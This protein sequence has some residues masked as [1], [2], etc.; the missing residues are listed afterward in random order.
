MAT[1]AWPLI[2]HARSLYDA[3]QCDRAVQVL[4]EAVRA[5]PGHREARGLLAE[6]LVD[7]ER[8]PDA[9]GVLEEAAGTSMPLEWLALKGLC[10]EA[11][12]DGTSASRI[13]E[14]LTQQD[15]GCVHGL[16]I[17]GR[18]AAR[19][20]DAALSERCFQEALRRDSR[21]GLA[22]LGLARLQQAAGDDPVCLEWLGKAFRSCPTSRE[23]VLAFHEQLIALNRLA[24]GEE[25]FRA[26]LPDHPLNRRLR[27]LLID[28]LLRQGKL[29]PA[30]AAVES[31]MAD[32]GVDAGILAAAG[33]VR[34]RLGPLRRVERG[35][36]GSDSV[37]LCM[38]VKNEEQH[39]ARCL[40]SA[41]PVVDEIVIVDTGSTDRT[42]DIAAAFGARVA[43]VSWSDDFSAARN[44][45]LELAG[46]EW[47]LVLDA[48]EV[49]SERDHDRFRQTVRAVKTRPAA[50]RMRTRNYTRH[51]NAVGWQANTGEY[52]EEEGPGWIPSDK[53][54][55]FT[56]DERIR[57]R[58]PVH[59]LVEPALRDVN[60][61]IGRCDIP[62]HHYGKLQEV[63]AHAKT[64]AYRRLGRSKLRHT[65]GDS[66]VLRE[67]A[68]QA[69]HMGQHEEAIRLWEQWVQLHPGAA[70]AYLNIGAAWWNLGRYTEAAGFADKALRLDPD[71]KEAGF[72]RAMAWLMS[73]RAEEAR[74]VL[75]EVLAKQADYPAARFMLGVAHACLGDPS[76]AEDAIEPLKELAIGEYIGESFAD[77]VQR[78]VA[79][80]L[81]DYAGRTLE[82]AT[83]MGYADEH[84]TSLVRG[85]RSAAE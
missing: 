42:R 74:G 32:F 20:G 10:H 40:R 66:P 80:S 46:C 79:A 41:K 53:V 61:A 9:L 69:S 64:K 39:L 83:H 6:L 77:V 11:L 65:K 36:A 1:R 76:R 37:S 57:F 33:N 3:G 29:D 7:S 26:T 55:L 19:S 4:T 25:A 14:R 50:F 13:A 63:T 47:V 82:A 78:M 22:G 43:D 51:V 84:L 85:C 24:H 15:A 45:A 23:I 70:D 8:Y 58:Y 68:I 48:D 67:L 21:C 73:G 35:S 62:V 28:L 2:E 72:N 5:E 81:S 44:A 12:G 49:L 75:E 71:L 34:G 30:M 18:L 31:A 60:I 27:F 59:E 38:I 52:P 16:V 56:R 54:R 17:R